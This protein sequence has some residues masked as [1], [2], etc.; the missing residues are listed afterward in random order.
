MT[1]NTLAPGAW[2]LRAAVVMTAALTLGCGDRLPA[3]PHAAPSLDHELLVSEP[4]GVQLAT[5]VAPIGDGVEASAWISPRGGVLLLP[6]AGLVMIFPRGAVDVSTRI[7]ARALPGE[8]VAYEFEPHGITFKQPVMLLQQ[9]NGVHGVDVSAGIP[10]FS[11]AYFADASQ[12]DQAAR[13]AY[14]NEFL[15]AAVDPARRL[16]SFSVHHFSGYMLASGRGGP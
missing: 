13:Q 6:E 8:V 16:V 1:R 10:S 14:A 7:T 12:I 5:R 4:V 2:G 9:F 15:P 11:G 3:G